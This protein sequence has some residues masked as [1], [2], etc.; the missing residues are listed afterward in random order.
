MQLTT[1]NL[2]KG[3]KMS[4]ERPKRMALIASQGTLDWAYPPFDF[5]VHCGCNGNGGGDLFHLLRIN[6]TE[7]EN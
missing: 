1:A 4:E 5:S 3:G 2:N 6:V 7:K